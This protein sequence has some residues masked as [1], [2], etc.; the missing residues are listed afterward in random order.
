[1][2][3]TPI[4][5]APPLLGERLSLVGETTRPA[6]VDRPSTVELVMPGAARRQGERLQTPADAGWVDAFTLSKQ[7][8]QYTGRSLRGANGTTA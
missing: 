5:L 1:M 3:M 4:G 6:L 7:V 8:L 2:M